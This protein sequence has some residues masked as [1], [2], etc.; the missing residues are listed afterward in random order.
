MNADTVGKLHLCQLALA[1]KLADLSSDELELCWL[2][3]EGFR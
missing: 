1:A 3:H 2:I